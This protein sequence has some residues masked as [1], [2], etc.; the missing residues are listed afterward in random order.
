[1]STQELQRMIEECKRML[2]ETDKRIE[3][4]KRI[5]GEAK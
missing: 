5:L 1:M 4:S 3:D 2:A